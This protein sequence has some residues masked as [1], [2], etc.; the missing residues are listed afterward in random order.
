[1]PDTMGMLSVLY[2]NEE[3]VRRWN[4]GATVSSN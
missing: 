2:A 4:Y 1:V 3:A